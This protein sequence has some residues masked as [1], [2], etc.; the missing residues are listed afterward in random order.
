MSSPPARRIKSFGST[1]DIL[2]MLDHRSGNK[3]PSRSASL[4]RNGK[5]SLESFSSANSRD[6]KESDTSSS[7]EDL[8]RLYHYHLQPQPSSNNLLLITKAVSTVDIGEEEEYTAV[9]ADKNPVSRLLE[10]SSTA[11]KA[12]EALGRSLIH[13][14]DSHTI[15]RS[16]DIFLASV[17]GTS[18]H[19]MPSQNPT[20]PLPRHRTSS[21][22]TTQ[23]QPLD[24][25]DELK[26]ATTPIFASAVLAKLDSWEIKLSSP[27]VT[28]LLPVPA[29][30]PNTTEP[31]LSSSRHARESHHSQHTKSPT[32]DISRFQS[33]A[34]MTLPPSMIPS[35]SSST[36][37]E[38]D[39]ARMVL[40]ASVSIRRKNS[41]K[42]LMQTEA[43]YMDDLRILVMHFFEIIKDTKCISSVEREAIVRNGA[44]ILAFQEEFSE[45]LQMAHGYDF[46]Q[47]ELSETPDVRRIAQCFIE[48]GPRF[49]VY[50]DYCVGQDKA[51]G[52][53]RYLLETNE[54][55][56]S[57]MERTHS[58]LRVSLGFGLSSK[59]A[60]DDYLITPFQR[61]FRYRLILQSITK[62]A[63]EGSDESRE[64]AI[65]Q[66]VM[67][68]IA[69]KLNMA[70]T[71]M[72]AEKKTDLFLTRLQSDWT[73][74]RRWHSTL[75]S[76]VLIG[77]LEV[78]YMQDGGKPKRYGCALF[79]TYMIIVKAKKSKHFYIPR[80]WFPL[81]KFDLM[82]I[83]D[84]EQSSMA[85]SWRLCNSDHVIEFGAMCEQEKQIWMTELHKA[86]HESKQQYASLNMDS[87][88]K[89]D[90][91]EQLFVSSF[92]K[93]DAKVDRLSPA[94][95]HSTLSLTSDQ[96]LSSQPTLSRKLSTLTVDGSIGRSHRRRP[97][98]KKTPSGNMATPG[99]NRMSKLFFMH[100]NQSMQRLHL[101]STQNQSSMSIGSDFPSAHPLA[102]PISDVGDTR[103][104]SLDTACS[105]ASHNE[106]FMKR[107][108]SSI[109]DFREFF[110]SNVAGKWS[111]RKYAQYQTKRM[112][113]DAKF[114]DVSTTPI[115]TARSQARQDGSF[116]QWRRRST[117]VDEHAAAYTHASPAS[118]L[119]CGAQ[120]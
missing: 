48:W 92:D 81:R 25:M 16:I 93:P 35:S 32:D 106:S 85:H 95:N 4:R 68:E 84:S 9:P 107:S 38:M 119:T 41:I 51:M 89:S 30:Q 66:D 58:F 40:E 1:E 102:S 60:F 6:F 56:S 80:H 54:A 28:P 31:A 117:L 113:V 94:S 43:K 111:Q 20:Q 11:S 64:L 105:T 14:V 104:F 17:H 109:I 47:H 12:C 67:H 91:I 114:E 99:S 34:T 115:L 37:L 15:Q 88:N 110:Q 73:L 83:E 3:K 57:L 103:P 33:E 74:P 69:T 53:Y 49:D 26:S 62:T 90:L 75:G 46:D 98:A 87:Q 45:A 97:S 116:E 8:H 101:P 82:D 112:A 78:H 42:E 24:E 39:S 100:G 65:A 13:I 120:R 22:S 29:M 44:D 59:L 18:F 70:K 7:I 86:I 76:C 27:P 52:T 61:V 36:S 108:Q 71:R 79:G 21:T 72:E 118:A 96:P 5:T 23:L 50:R 2:A 19:A 63:N 55:F 10:S 77:T